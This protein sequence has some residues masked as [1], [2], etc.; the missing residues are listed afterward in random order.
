M[1]KGLYL[2]PTIC[3]LPIAFSK[4]MLKFLNIKPENAPLQDLHNEGFCLESNSND[5]LQ[6]T[7]NSVNLQ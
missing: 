4:T 7:S 1:G 5:N 2:I 3:V 6:V